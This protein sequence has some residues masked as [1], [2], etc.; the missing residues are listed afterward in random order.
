MSLVSHLP[1]WVWKCVRSREGD[2]SVPFCFSL[3]H[4]RAD[5]LC[6]SLHPCCFWLCHMSCGGLSSLTRDRTRAM[7]VKAQSPN[8]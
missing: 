5:A 7:E 4:H 1:W 8:H 2:A 6:G 3:K